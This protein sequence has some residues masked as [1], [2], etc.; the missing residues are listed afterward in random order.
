MSIPSRPSTAL[1]GAVLLGGLGLSAS[2]LAMTELAQG[3][4][5]GAQGAAPPSA[6]K[7]ASTLPAQPTSRSTPANATGAG[8]AAEA[9]G[10][11]HAQHA[12]AAKPDKSDAAAAK[13]DDKAMAEG[14]CG[15]GKCGGGG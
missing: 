7:A 9:S 10:A 12:A 5:L 8:K 4:A 15:E 1:A 6:D 14:K 3:Y 13:H 2:A 11:A